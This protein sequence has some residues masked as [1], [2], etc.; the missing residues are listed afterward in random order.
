MCYQRINGN[1]KYPIYKLTSKSE[2]NLAEVN[3]HIEVFM[4]IQDTD[5]SFTHKKKGFEGVGSR[6]NSNLRD[7]KTID[8]WSSAYSQNHAFDR[9][10]DL[11]DHFAPNVI[12]LG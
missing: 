7:W 10:F 2:V 6:E 12:D 5:L 11:L 4:R 1:I 8:A 9:R 3:A